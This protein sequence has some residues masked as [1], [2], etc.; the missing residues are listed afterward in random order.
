[1]VDATPVKHVAFKEQS[2]RGTVAAEA[3]AA[4]AGAA[5]AAAA[6]AAANNSKNNIGRRHLDG[7]GPRGAPARGRAFICMR[8]RSCSSSQAGA[9]RSSARVRQR[10]YIIEM[11][12]SFIHIGIRRVLTNL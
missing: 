2:K 7:R 6:A 12:H 1:M 5:A 9:A 10:S 3:V 8:V 4:V 11:H